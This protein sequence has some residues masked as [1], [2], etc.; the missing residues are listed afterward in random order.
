MAYVIEVQG[1]LTTNLNGVN[2]GQFA[3]NLPPSP[4]PTHTHIHTQYL[5]G[6]IRPPTSSGPLNKLLHLSEVSFPPV[7]KG[8]HDGYLFSGLHKITNIYM[9][10]T[11]HIVDAS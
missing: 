9:Y 10:A 11:W 5:K 6:G 4:I 8:S 3:H 2:N 1:G 7:E